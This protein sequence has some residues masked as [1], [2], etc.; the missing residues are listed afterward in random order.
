MAN[1][2]KT[3]LQIRKIIQLKEDGNSLRQISCLTGIHRK[4]IVKYCN[5]IKQ[6][7]K[8]C[9]ELLK[10]TDVEL[11][12]LLL[13][14]AAEEEVIDARYQWLE[15]KMEYYAHE[16]E[17]KDVTRQLLWEEYLKEQPNGYGRTQF[18]EHLS[19]HR[20]IRQAT[21]HLNYQPGERMEV[22]FAG[23]EMTYI[24]SSTGEVIRCPVLVC[25][26]PYSGFTY[27]EPLISAR[28]EHLIPALNRALTYFGGV[29]QRVITDNMTQIV[30]RSCRYEPLFTE[31]TEQWA[32]HYHTYFNSARVRKPKDKPSVEKAVH[33][34][35]QRINA[36]MRNETCF[37]LAQLKN[38]CLE[39]LD[40]FND[41]QMYKREESRRQRF[42]QE[43]K[44]FLKPLPAGPFT[45]HH[46]TGA[47][48]KK[49]YHVILGEDWHQYSVPHQ[50]IGQQVSIIYDEHI[51]EIFIKLQRIAVHKRDY[52]KYGYTTQP[53]HM[54]ESHRRY[55]EQRGW[56]SDDFIDRAGRIGNHTEKA[57][58]CLLS[59]KAFIEQTY[60]S[61]LGV[62]R[63]SDK[64]GNDRL[65]A[66]CKR[67]TQSPH[68]TYRIIKNILENNLDKVPLAGTECK[69]LIPDHE[70]IRGPQAYC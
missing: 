22:D 39:L 1:K 10:L 54:P 53:E 12:E 42:N 62:L 46:K 64:Y 17:N 51:V 43:E 63:L 33:L 32:A 28:L 16:L 56:T 5:R 68:I 27:L 48:V 66:A 36:R 4:T 57:I 61:C 11:S 34:S 49:N 9:Q 8:S 35:Y 69:L 52:R 7:G 65:E 13:T 24:D 30:T 3:M 67:A 14:P 25:I 19:R 15:G 41:R 60:D 2:T 59:S 38:R 50:Y 29:P 44:A 47:K 40:E 55:L 70:N 18:Y 20:C 23:E 37:N 26:L 58:R 45:I 31:M 6:T 21:L